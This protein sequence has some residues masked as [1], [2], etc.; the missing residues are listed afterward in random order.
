MSASLN[1]CLWGSSAAGLRTEGLSAEALEVQP[2]PSDSST[3]AHLRRPNRVLTTLDAR[4]VCSVSQIG[5]SRT[6]LTQPANYS[7]FDRALTPPNGNESVLQWLVL[8]CGIAMAGI[9]T[10]WVV[11]MSDGG[12]HLKIEAS[13]LLISTMS[14]LAYK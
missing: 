5:G 2:T 12:R 1:P 4:L 8:T 6:R 10:R 13:R 14:T 3:L 9:S 7:H 11:S